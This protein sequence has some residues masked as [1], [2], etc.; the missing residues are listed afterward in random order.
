MPTSAC[1]GET[2]RELKERYGDLLRAQPSF[3][4]PEVDRAIDALGAA[5]VR[6]LGRR[7]VPG[8]QQMTLDLGGAR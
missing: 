8:S 2:A 7:E 1:I 6:M 5:Q 4:E 3:H